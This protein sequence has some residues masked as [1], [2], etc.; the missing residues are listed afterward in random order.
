MT[1][2]CRRAP[3]CACTHSRAH[4]LLIFFRHSQPGG[5]NQT[6]PSMSLIT[7]LLPPKP[8][9]LPRLLSVY[10]KSQAW[11]SFTALIL[12]KSIFRGYFF[13]LSPPIPPNPEV[14]EVFRYKE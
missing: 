6:D 7:L 10:A 12:F 3:A 4:A 1:F 13:S 11:F 8:F 9:Q 2:I 5:T 14:E